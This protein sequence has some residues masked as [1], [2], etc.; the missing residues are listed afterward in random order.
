MGASALSGATLAGCMTTPKAEIV[1]TR[2]LDVWQR[3]TDLVTPDI[4]YRY[5]RGEQDLAAYASLVKLESGFAKVLSEIDAADVSA[6]PAVWMVY[7]MGVVVKTKESLFA[8]DLMHRRATELAPKLDFA[9]VTHYHGDHYHA[10]L[11]RAMDGAGKTVISNFLCNY[12]PQDSSAK[13]GYTRAEKVFKIK[14]VEVRTSLTDHNDYLVDF[15]TAFEIRVGDWRMYHS[16]DC[17]NVAKLNPVWGRP[18]L[19]VVFPGCG[20]D[21][22]AGERKLRPRQ[23]S[24]GH[25][26]ELGHDSGRLTTPMVRDARE[27]VLSAGG[28]VTVPLWGERIV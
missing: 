22:A 4:Y 14:D 11:Y 17:S 24:F 13:G 15:T 2:D 1:D 10:G 6:H 21:I 19:W 12:G 23:M 3:E 9:L 28:N 27:K 7:N 26:W 5:F 25:L 8:I 18:D 20:I 16:G